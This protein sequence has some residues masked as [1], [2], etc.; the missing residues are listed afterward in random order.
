MIV[1]KERDR[2]FQN[3]IATYKDLFVWRFFTGHL[4]LNNV[5]YIMEWFGN[6]NLFFACTDDEM[7]LMEGERCG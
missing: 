7:Q 6:D 4:F 2:H 3:I 5:Y 1:R